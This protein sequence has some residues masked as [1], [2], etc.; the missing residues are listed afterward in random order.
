MSALS[1][2]LFHNIQLKYGCFYNNNNNNRLHIYCCCGCILLVISIL[3]FLKI[4]VHLLIIFTSV[5][6]VLQIWLVPYFRCSINSE[7]D[8]R[9][10]SDTFISGISTNISQNSFQCYHR[11]PFFVE[12]VIEPW[13]SL[14]ATPH[15]F[16]SVKSFRTCLLANDLR[17]FLV[18]T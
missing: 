15:D 6:L 2:L 14:R 5:E 17:E 10:T 4:I 7:Q 1:F 18:I 16:S 11:Q 13:N 9:K 3:F 8:A 12:R